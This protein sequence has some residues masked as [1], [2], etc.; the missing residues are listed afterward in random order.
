[1]SAVELILTV[2][3]ILTLATGGVGERGGKKRKRGV[4]EKAPRFGV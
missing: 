2:E 1:L 4:S 3:A